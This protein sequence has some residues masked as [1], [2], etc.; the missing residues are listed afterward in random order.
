[1]YSWP[2]R[3]QKSKMCLKS[4]YIGTE[5]AVDLHA[6]AGGPALVALPGGCSG[7]AALTEARRRRARAASYCSCD[8]ML[9]HR[10]KL[11]V[12]CVGSDWGKAGAGRWSPRAV[13]S[14]GRVAHQVERGSRWARE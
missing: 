4:R 6:R 1:M 3:R 8:M 13:R 14:V 9:S 11:G 12:V 5:G 7:K 2:V 10:G